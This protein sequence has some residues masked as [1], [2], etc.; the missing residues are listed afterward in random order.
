MKTL[1][2]PTEISLRK[3]IA[4]LR[5][6]QASG[7]GKWF[8][9]KFIKRTTGEDRVMLCRFDVKCFEKGGLPAYDPD[10]KAL[11]WVCDMQIAR[12][13]RHFEKNNIPIPPHLKRELSTP[14]RSINLHCILELRI[15]GVDYKIVKN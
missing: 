3:A 13:I 10:E 2:R 6:I 7:C 5:E 11:L 14:Y 8:R 1:S 15:D 4:L 12:R 9:V